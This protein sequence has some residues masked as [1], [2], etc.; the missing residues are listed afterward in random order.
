MKKVLALLFLS[1]LIVTCSDQDGNE[2]VTGEEGQGPEPT[3]AQ[4][5]IDV[6]GLDGIDYTNVTALSVNAESSI[7]AF[8]IFENPHV[9]NGVE[10]LP[11]LLI[12]NDKLLLGYYPDA[13]ASNKI[14]IDDL[15][16]F[17][18]LTYPQISIQGLD[19]TVLLDAIRSS[20]YYDTLV[21]I[22]EEDLNN[23]RTPLENEEFIALLRE[24]T[25]EVDFSSSNR[26]E[27][28]VAQYSFDYARDGKIQWTEE[29][30]LFANMGIVIVDEAANEL[31]FGPELLK[32]KNLEISASSVIQWI[33]SEFGEPV[34]PRTGSYTLPGNGEYKIILTNGFSD[35]V[36][37][38]LAINTRNRNQFCATSVGLFIGAALKTIAN[39]D[40]CVEA[41][42][43]FYTRASLIFTSLFATPNIDN[44]EVLD[45][46]K[47]AGLEFLTALNECVSGFLY[48]FVKAILLAAQGLLN[49]PLDIAELLLM[50]RD[51][52]NS[53]ITIEETRYFENGI[54]FGDMELRNP[55][56]TL[57]TGYLGENFEFRAEVVEEY[58]S[59]SVVRGLTESYFDLEIGYAQVEGLPFTAEVISGD[60]TINA[61]GP[62]LSGEPN[63]SGNLVVPFTMGESNSEIV[64]SPALNFN[65]I[66]DI[67]ISATLVESP[68]IGTWDLFEFGGFPA[69]ENV[70]D[71]AICENGFENVSI[72]YY[73]TATFTQ[74]TFEAPVGREQILLDCNTG[75]VQQPE[76][77]YD[78]P[79]YYPHSG[80]YVYLGDNTFEITDDEDQSL[81][82]VNDNELHLVLNDGTIKKYTR[83]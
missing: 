68:I 49:A 25:S 46:L 61:A 42:T 3:Q 54:S 53:D 69:N 62:I 50:M 80:T 55:S 32:T 36:D 58:N 10:E 59:Y 74:N 34:P 31:V 79:D 17:Y 1:L 5:K 65:E 29:V 72:K 14:Q 40:A 77:N 47:A 27:E 52:F 70:Y 78:I 15:L 7:D 9:S 44:Q 71:G 75:N 18:F 56:Q 67:T 19:K 73:G 21:A 28:I 64:I 45:Q 81:I 48:K 30:P 33:N 2:T 38:N 24:F 41:V 20:T 57:Y 8:G 23:N 6:G 4:V 37:L 35:N 13:T 39:N 51:Y 11:V 63:F 76:F 26:S 12:E 60:A 82:L 22:V 43:A 83:Q 16:L 66:E